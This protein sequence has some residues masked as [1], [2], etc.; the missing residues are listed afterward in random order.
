MGCLQHQQ[1]LPGGVTPD[2]GRRH[3]SRCASLRSH[4]RGAGIE[5]TVR[6]ENTSSRRALNRLLISFI[7][8]GAARHLQWGG[9]G[10]PSGVPLNF[11]RPPISNFLLGFRPL[12]FAKMKKKLFIG[13][14]LPKK[15]KMPVECPLESQGLP[16][17]NFLLVFRPLNF[18]NMLKRF[19]F[20]FCRK[21][22]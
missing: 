3:T 12:H 20:N 17:F 4:H 13:K 8:R 21:K 2:D 18:G 1:A 19:F 7:L 5:S 14:V 11:S 22:R 10:T 9:G 16:N 15:V 6:M